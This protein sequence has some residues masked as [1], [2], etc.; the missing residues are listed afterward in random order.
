MKDDNK[1][2]GRIPFSII[3][4]I[5]LL[6]GIAILSYALYLHDKPKRVDTKVGNCLYLDDVP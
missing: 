6:L 2:H 4:V 5:A 1:E 3:A